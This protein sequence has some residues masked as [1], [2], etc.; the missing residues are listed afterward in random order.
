MQSK[1]KSILNTLFCSFVSAKAKL[2][3]V[4]DPQQQAATMSE[5][6]SELKNKKTSTKKTT[7]KEKKESPAGKQKKA[8]DLAAALANQQ[9]KTK[10]ST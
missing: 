3:T 10:T 9:P 4:L 2:P 7:G 1:T 8:S 5:L 6:I